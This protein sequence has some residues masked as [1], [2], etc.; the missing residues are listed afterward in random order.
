MATKTI[1]TKSAY[2]IVGG[3]A[4]GVYTAYEVARQHQVLHGEKARIVIV[5]MHESV[6]QEISGKHAA[7]LT[8]LE[9]VAGGPCNEHFGRGF[10]GIAEGCWLQDAG[11]LSDRE[12][13]FYNAMTMG[14]MHPLEER[15][16]QTRTQLLLGMASMQEWQKFMAEHPD[17]AKQCFFQ[18]R[19][20]SEGGKIRILKNS[21]GKADAAV[22]VEMYKSIGV[23]IEFVDAKEA[24]AKA[25]QYEPALV[26]ADFV[27]DASR[28]PACFVRE[29]GG[30]MDPR[31]FCEAMLAMLQ[32]EHDV[33]F[34]G[35]TE[36]TGVRFGG[37]SDEI[38]GL[39]TK[40]GEIV[41]DFSSKYVFAT[42]AGKFPDIRIPSVMG[43]A[44]V[45]ITIPIT[46][47][48]VAQNIPCPK[49][50]FKLSTEAGPISV[51]V[52]I[53]EDG[54][55]EIRVGG[56]RSFSGEKRWGLDH[57]FVQW[58]I[59]TLIAE[60]EKILPEVIQYTKEHMGKHALEDTFGAWTNRRPTT[61]DM[62][63]I[64]G[65]L[66]NKNGEQ[67][68]NGFVNGA[69]ASGGTSI[70]PLCAALVARLALEE[71]IK[72]PGLTERDAQAVAASLDPARFYHV[73]DV[74]RGIDAAQAKQIESM[75]EISKRRRSGKISDTALIALWGMQEK[76]AACLN[77]SE[78]WYDLFAKTAIDWLL[79]DRVITKEEI[80]KLAQLIA[81]DKIISPLETYFIAKL[82]ERLE[83]YAL[84]GTE[85]PMSIFNAAIAKI[86]HGDD[87][88][89]SGTDTALDERIHAMRNIVSALHTPLMAQDLGKNLQVY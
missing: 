4:V 70:S 16:K 83:N 40:S 24:A 68:K 43:V 55:G 47:E 74:V 81:Q 80:Q 75:L 48:M 79:E 9:A 85:V 2:I 13:A 62:M 20:V 35:N 28:T 38:I 73:P 42:G 67:I 14:A 23:E 84:I 41:G 86:K 44:G 25:T 19:G 72:L 77:N 10:D 8:A 65:H 7:S 34:L 50:S 15:M 88:N 36:I 52:L 22:F 57:D 32:K 17:I 21:L 3:G 82:Q 11:V 5:D 58:G 59:R 54:T 53:G 63:P 76:H 51:S 61:P 71:N 30:S 45:T 1:D 49:R 29:P 78:E 87:L 31:L 37:N 12:R 27:Q 18:F 69:H 6:G 64:V 39:V 56:L 66:L 33:K 46:P 60:T 26:H 89:F